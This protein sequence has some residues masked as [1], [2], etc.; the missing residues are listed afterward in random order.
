LTAVAMLTLR[1]ASRTRLDA[2][3]VLAIAVALLGWVALLAAIQLRVQAVSAQRITGAG[4]LLPTLVLGM[5]G[6]G[7]LGLVL[8]LRA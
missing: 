6:Y 4:R 3:G 5:L 2:L 7:L 1:V 8:T